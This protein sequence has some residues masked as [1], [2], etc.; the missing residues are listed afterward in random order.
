MLLTSKKVVIQASLLHVFAYTK[1]FFIFPTVAQELNQVGVRELPQKFHFYLYPQIHVLKFTS[2][3]YLLVFYDTNP[4]IN[5]LIITN[6][7]H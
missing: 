2:I 5:M 3:L 7:Y 4:L 6:L 1:V